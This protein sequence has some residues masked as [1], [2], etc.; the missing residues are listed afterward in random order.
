MPPVQKCLVELPSNRGEEREGLVCASGPERTQTAVAKSTTAVITPG[1]GG[2]GRSQR[3]GAGWG[4]VIHQG[5]TESEYWKGQEAG[6][7]KASYIER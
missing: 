2:G 5:Q 7:T 3:E 4:P 6:K 1:R